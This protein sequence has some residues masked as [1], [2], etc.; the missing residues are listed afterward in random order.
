MK[1]L[2]LLATILA[3]FFY[4]T[5]TTQAASVNLNW[6]YDTVANILQPAQNAVNAVIKASSFQSSSSTV[7]NIFPKASST[8]FCLGS[9]CRTSWPT[10]GGSN[11]FTQVP[12]GLLTATT[13]DYV[14][15]ANFIGSSTATSTFLNLG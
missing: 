14:Q 3:L 1:K 5:A 12:G 7:T 13:T 15:A 6:I 4:T 8:T 2:L 9:D 10:G 11:Q